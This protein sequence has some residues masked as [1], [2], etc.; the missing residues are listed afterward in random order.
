MQ[1]P[2]DGMKIMP[3]CN[4]KKSSCDHRDTYFHHRSFERQK[5]TATN[6]HQITVWLP[7]SPV[8]GS[9]PCFL[10]PIHFW[11]ACIRDV[12]Y[13]IHV[14][15][16]LQVCKL[17]SSGLHSKYIYQLNHL[18]AQLWISSQA[19]GVSKLSLQSFRAV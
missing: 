14:F 15:P 4:L 12:H 8:W 2:E 18:P 11:S 19:M 1:I 7:G 10:L 6:P 13:G 16:R 17:S 9:F 5:E 3:S